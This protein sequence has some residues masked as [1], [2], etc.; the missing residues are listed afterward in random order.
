MLNTARVTDYRSFIEENFLI[1]DKYNQPVPFKFNVV[2]NKVYD[3]WENKKV[4]FMWHTPTRNYPI[5]LDGLREDILK[6]RQ[7]GVSSL[8]LAMFSVDFLTLPFS[9][10]ICISHRDP[11]TRKLFKKVVFFIESACAKRK[12]PLKSI[13][14][15]DDVA[16]ASELYN[17]TNGAGFWIA[18]A[19]TKVGGRG[20]TAKNILFSENAFYPDTAM[21]RAAEIV[22]GTAQ[23]VAQDY[24][25]I[26]LETTA[27]GYGNYSH[28]L[29]KKASRG[30]SEYYPLFLAAKENPEYTDEWLAKKFRSFTSRSMALQEYPNTPIEAFIMSG[31]NFF[32]K[33]VLDLL[34]EINEYYD[35]LYHLYY[36][37]EP[38]HRP[39]QP[40]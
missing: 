37:F 21:M 19:G 31:A 40:H 33:E 30:L 35:A 8:V 17:V 3:L 6:A 22:E 38:E 23:Q 5:T 9:G 25:M 24:G 29:W 10:S 4:D 11:D 13:L 12:I 26:I 1:I 18:T 14:G 7:E 34:K 15:R 20:T 32:D 36:K 28:D 39:G 27:N 16:N 2:Q